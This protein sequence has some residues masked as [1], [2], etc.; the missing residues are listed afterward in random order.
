MHLHWGRDIDIA[1]NVLALGQNF[2]FENTNQDRTGAYLFRNNVLLTQA[3]HFFGDHGLKA[4][5][6]IENNLYLST[7]GAKK[8]FPGDKDLIAWKKREPSASDEDPEFK[9]PLAGDFTALRPA[10]LAARG[11]DPLLFATAG[12]LSGATSVSSRPVWDPAPA[13]GSNPFSANFD[14]NGTDDLAGFFRS[15]AS[16]AQGIELSTER[17]HSAPRALKFTDGPLGAVWQP[18]ASREVFI[19]DGIVHVSLWLW[20]ENGAMPWVTLRD[21]HESIVNGPSVSVTADGHLSAGGLPIMPCPFDTWF[22]IDMTF[23]IGTSR[24]GTWIL[25][26]TTETGGEKTF[27]DLPLP[28]T[29]LGFEW[30]GIAGYGKV[31]AKFFVD[32]ISVTVSD[33]R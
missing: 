27:P 9:N 17:S 23:G 19:K 7:A 26:V 20:A 31:A 24:T 30:F 4:D 12:R 5:V 10:P 22:K 18:L 14:E 33:H 15:V 32:D 29:F 2:V 11:I 16:P 28:K 1:S 3:K 21:I 13:P 8:L 6:K 25:T